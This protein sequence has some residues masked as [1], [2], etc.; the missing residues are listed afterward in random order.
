MTIIRYPLPDRRTGRLPASATIDTGLEIQLNI[1]SSLLA[2]NMRGTAGSRMARP[3][4]KSKKTPT[5]QV[6]GHYPRTAERVQSGVPGLAAPE[7]AHP[8]FP[9][10]AQVLPL[11]VRIAEAQAL[12]TALLPMG[13]RRRT[14]LHLE[15]PSPS[16]GFGEIRAALRILRP[17]STIFWR[18]AV[19]STICSTRETFCSLVTL[20]A[21]LRRFL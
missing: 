19:P 15:L 3:A 21:T 18:A 1:I 8:T 10:Q 12:E 11:D 17:W 14:T 20:S 2:R 9:S 16:A 5:K 6:T 4:H 13:T 7:T